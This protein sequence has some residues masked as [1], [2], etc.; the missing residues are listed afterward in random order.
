VR[1]P[2]EDDDVSDALETELGGLAKW[3]VG[4]R[5]LSARLSGVETSAFLQA[6]LRRGTL[7]PARW[8]S[9]CW[10]T[11]SGR[12]TSSWRAACRCTTGRRRSSTSRSTSAAGAG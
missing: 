7:P 6:E 1:V 4:E 8:A 10:T 2:D 12:S 5:M 3:N 11:C 9:R